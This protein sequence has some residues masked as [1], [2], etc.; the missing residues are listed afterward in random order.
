MTSVNIEDGTA[1]RRYHHGDLPA[2]LIRSATALVEKQGLEAFTVREVARRVGVS[3]TAPYRHFADRQELLAAVAE[4]GFA[5][6]GT[7]TRAAFEAEQDIAEAFLAVGRAYVRFAVAHPVLFRLMFEPGLDA[8][9]RT[10]SEAR[11]AAFAVLLGAVAT[12]QQ[13]GVL[14]SGDIVEV[15]I[16]AWSTVHGLA[17]LVIDR[18]LEQ[19]LEGVRPL[20]E[21]VD[22]VTRL[23]LAGIGTATHLPPDDR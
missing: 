12:A 16:T 19:R 18:A 14:R 15:A 7:N 10:L 11:Q 21:W 5:Q 20:D 4:A 1:E 13:A 22:V 8:A 6:L 17:Q 23:G 2:A 3:H 9:R